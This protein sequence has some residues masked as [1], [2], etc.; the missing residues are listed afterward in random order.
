MLGFRKR[1]P[2]FESRR[3]QPRFD[4]DLNTTFLR[5]RTIVGSA[6]SRVRAASE[7]RGDVLS[8]RMRVHKLRRH[9]RRARM[10]LAI[11]AAICLVFGLL[12]YG[13]LAE[14]RF[15]ASKQ[16]GAAVDEAVYRQAWREYTTGRP[17]ES[18]RYF[19]NGHQWL[20]FLRQKNPE[21]RAMRIEAIFGD[22]PVMILELRQ[23]IAVWRVGAEALYVDG[24]GV[25]FKK[26]YFS[27]PTVAVIDESGVAGVAAE[28]AVASAQTM[29]FIGQVIAGVEGAGKDKIEKIVLPPGLL[30]QADIY[31][32]G[33][34]YR[35]KANITRDPAHQVADILATLRY[36]DQRQLKPEYLDT[37]V[38]S[39][40]F[41]R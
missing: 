13:S 38:A 27:E 9:H 35:I 18:I 1:Q 17:H 39:K 30:R 4:Q 24:E 8:D 41:I 12:I 21:V 34:P 28:R 14:V 2:K 23:P 6:S 11:S 16:V 29:A 36:I 26:N 31:L 15:V 32:V 7:E 40:L 22:R 3:R 33:R 37:R 20:E 5:S 25:A 10:A 19:L